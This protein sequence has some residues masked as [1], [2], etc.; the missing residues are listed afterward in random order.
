MP[1]IEGGKD[2]RRL[3]NRYEEPMDMPEYAAA[4]NGAGKPEVERTPSP[5]I[6][7]EP[8]DD[9]DYSPFPVSSKVDTYDPTKAQFV[10]RPK[11][12]TI[13]LE[14]DPSHVPFKNMPSFDRILSVSGGEMIEPPTVCFTGQYRS[15]QL[16]HVLVCHHETKTSKPTACGWNCMRTLGSEK[17]SVNGH[18]VV[19][20]AEE[21]QSKRQKRHA[22]VFVPRKRGSTIERTTPYPDPAT[23]KQKRRSSRLTERDEETIELN[24]LVATDKGHA[25][26]AA[27][28]TGP[29][30]RTKSK[31]HPGYAL[32]TELR[33]EFETEQMF[34]TADGLNIDFKA[35]PMLKRELR[36]LHVDG[37]EK[38]RGMGAF[39]PSVE[40]D[41]A[42]AAFMQH[43]KPF[44]AD[45]ENEKPWSYANSLNAKPGRKAIRRE[46]ADMFSMPENRYNE[47]VEEENGVIIEQEDV[48]S[49]R[50]PRNQLD[51]GDLIED[52]DAPTLQYAQTC[53]VC[54]EQGDDRLEE[55]TMCRGHF[56]SACVAKAEEVRAATIE[57]DGREWYHC[58]G[59]NGKICDKP[60][61]SLRYICTDSA[62]HDFDW[63]MDCGKEAAMQHADDM[64]GKGVSGIHKLIV[65][66]G[67]R[68]EALKALREED[69]IPFTCSSCDGQKKAAQELAQQILGRKNSTL[70]K[71]RRQNAKHRKA[72]EKAMNTPEF[73][74]AM[75]DRIRDNKNRVS[76]PSST[77]RSKSMSKSAST[78]R[79]TSSRSSA[80]ATAGP[81]SGLEMIAEEGE[82]LE[83]EDGLFY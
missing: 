30:V 8:T 42:N 77:S 62:C 37:T 51:L 70:E 9:D 38:L 35:A 36:N 65:I 20:D 52:E 17:K 46:D 5:F 66:R 25:I 79:R 63:C 28:A 10:S 44:G 43:D 33:E 67:P 61:D 16:V 19:C 18:E 48:R 75:Q 15:Q 49:H 23:K 64:A 58:D 80:A 26:L 27:R 60:L 40:Q 83:M 82:D 31:R 39:G 22:A 78:P 34:K 47:M 50:L 56:H 21:C 32:S 3:S 2:T 12:K 76:K 71:I 41:A 45:T 29:G 59:I 68:N 4:R 7:P 55:C 13:D 72:Q 81:M 53:G 1:S 24:Q 69:K 6:K 73:R 54:D 57:D 74:E 11:P 14:Y